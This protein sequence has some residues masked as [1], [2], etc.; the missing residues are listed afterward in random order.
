MDISTSNHSMT[1][2]GANVIVCVLDDGVEP[3]GNLTGRAYAVNYSSKAGVNRQGSHGT[4]VA[5]VVIDHCPEAIIYSYN[6]RDTG[7]QVDAIH[8]ALADILA[9]AKSDTRR[10]IV[11]MSFAG[12]GNTSN[13]SI[14]EMER[15]VNLLV[16]ANVPV[17]V[18]AGNDGEDV[19]GN[20]WPSC[21]REVICVSALKNDGTRAQFSAWHNEVDFG[22]LGDPVQALDIN[23]AMRGMAGTSFATPIVGGKMRNAVIPVSQH[24]GA[25]IVRGAQGQRAGYGGCGA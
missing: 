3:I 13:A 2:G 18:G 22:E 8:A 25:G 5:S 7:Y 24:D 12:D 15:R 4:A 19:T 10:Y 11:N 16:E 17:V 9:R 21:F 23:G 20:K 14:A 6:I 1:G